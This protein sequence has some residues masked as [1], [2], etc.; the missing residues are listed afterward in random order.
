MSKFAAVLFLVLLCAP[1][2]A[3]QNPYGPDYYRAEFWS[4]EYPAG[5]TVLEDTVLKLR[6]SL[7]P[8][9]EATID[10]PVSKGATYHPWNLPRVADEGLSF[11]SF[12]RIADYEVQ[13]PYEANLFN[14]AEQT[15]ATIS[16]KPGDRW[17]YIVYY[18]EGTFL[19][20]YDGVRYTG[21]QGLADASK[22]L[23][24]EGELTYTE[25][26]RIDCSNNMWGWLVMAEALEN[27]AL[28]SPNILQYGE[29]A[30]VQ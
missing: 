18:A 26:L 17:R 16:F 24:P 8:D 25:W 9:A 2:A 5:F 28:G 11:V 12:S 15:D 20:E 27:P 19:M 23:T 6:P 13:T 14:E 7:S 22:A 1:A 30:D 3:Q 21:D 29:A 10:C 4:G